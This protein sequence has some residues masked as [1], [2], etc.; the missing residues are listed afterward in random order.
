MSTVRASS[1]VKAW[2]SQKA[3]QK[4]AS[5]EVCNLGNQL[6][7]DPAH[8]FLAAAGKLRRHGVRRQQRGHD[9][10][11]A[12]GVEAGHHAQH[13]QLRL[14]IQ[15]VAGFGFDGGRAGAQ[16]PVAMPARLG[17]QIVFRGCAR[18]F[19]RAQNAAAGSGN[20][21]IGGAGNALL[22]LGGA[23]AREDQMRVRIDKARRDAAA[24]RV[25]HDC[26]GR[27]LGT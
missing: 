3:S 14:A 27:N 7:R 19:H 18:G 1:T 26:I 25:D 22:E 24:L 20:L 4:R 8:I 16:H 11:R 5:F 2:S 17:Q 21:L 12:L 23:I 6:F 15:P 13:A 9:A 10:R